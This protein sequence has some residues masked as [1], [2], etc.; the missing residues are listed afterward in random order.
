MVDSVADASVAPTP[1]IAP[2]QLIGERYLVGEVLGGGG[3]G[4]VCA[5]THVLLGTPVA[6]KLIHSDLKQ[7]AEAVQRFMNEARASAG[8]KGEHIARVF[9][10]GLLD[11]GEPYLVMEQLE[12]TSLDQYLQSRGPLGQQE[13]ADIVLQACEGLAEAHA[14]GL[15]HRDIKPAN[16]FLARLPSGQYSLKILDFGIVKQRM[17]Q[18]TPALTNPG[19]S[20]G[21]PWYMS[22]EQML[23]PAQVDERADVW[24]L[25]VLLFELL[26]GK[27]PF[28]GETVPQVCAIVLTAP[29]PQLSEARSDVATELDEIVSHCLEKQPERRFATVGQLAQ[30]LQ[31]FASAPTHGSGMAL[32]DAEAL[33][34]PA[35]DQGPAP[36]YGSLVPL[37][38]GSSHPS[39]RRVWRPRWTALAALPVLVVV[40]VLAFQSGVI[41]HAVAASRFSTPSARLAD[42]PTDVTVAARGEEDAITLLQ[43]LHTG[44]SF[45]EPERTPSRPAA[46]D[47]VTASAPRPGREPA[48]DAWPGAP[49]PRR[50]DKLEQ[51]P[52]L[53]A[54]ETAPSPGRAAPSAPPLEPAPASSA[55][56]ELLT[57][58]AFSTPD[59]PSNDATPP[60]SSPAAP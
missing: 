37:S 45:P 32:D 26:T 25:G 15:V 55:P 28:D 22:P 5:G 57:P 16:L 41:W 58:P 46:G 47:E 36:S 48:Y 31:P 21:S 54:P 40:A 7:D 18:D 8:L 20:L 27:R 30:A 6:I 4:V 2:G 52:L 35:S 38:T 11:S 3:M 9:D 43:T 29:T 24:S 12:G 1:S 51:S 49:S 10:V 59:S 44:Q 23:T 60:A 33:R 13:A 19:K 42:S 56:P 17:D 14:A 53:P 50:E 34:E 39:R